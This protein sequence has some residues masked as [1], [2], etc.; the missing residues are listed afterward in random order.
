MSV[1]GLCRAATVRHFTAPR[2]NT[3]EP[4][5]ARLRKLAIAAYWAASNPME[6]KMAGILLDLFAPDVSD[7]PPGVTAQLVVWAR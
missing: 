2:D 6:A 5:A 7:R 4:K 3:R 1:Y